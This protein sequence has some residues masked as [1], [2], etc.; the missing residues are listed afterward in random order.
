LAKNYEEILELLIFSN[1]FFKENVDY[2]MKNDTIKKFILKNDE[3]F[4][5]IEVLANE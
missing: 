1:N 2:L 3:I 5:K 4:D